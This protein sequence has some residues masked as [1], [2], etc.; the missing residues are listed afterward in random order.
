MLKTYKV[1]RKGLATLSIPFTLP[2]GVISNVSSINEALSKKRSFNTSVIV[3]HSFYYDLYIQGMHLCLI[4]EARLLLDLFKHNVFASVDH[5]SSMW[6][7][8]TYNTLKPGQNVPRFADV[9]FKLIFFG[10]NVFIL[11]HY[12]DFIMTTMA[13]QTTSLTIVYSSVYS[14][15]DQRK[16]QSSA[17]LV[18]VREITPVTGEFPA[19]MASNAGNVS[20][21]WRH[22]E[23]YLS[24][25]CSQVLIAT[26]IV[27]IY[28]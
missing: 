21:W 8:F 1:P 4:S 11:V 17:S 5:H 27:C 25:R 9:A 23:I 16:H 6:C 14:G 15:A 2:R 19:K 13:S 7:A 20:I 3:R 18:F 10:A 22:H 26:N 28:V 24:T 12:N